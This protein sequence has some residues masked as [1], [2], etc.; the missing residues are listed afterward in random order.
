MATYP[1]ER[2]WYAAY[3]SHTGRPDWALVPAKPAQR[4]NTT[5]TTNNNNRLSWTSLPTR[6][7][8]A[9]RL[10]ERRSA[11]SVCE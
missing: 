2:A 4:L 10:S 8:T 6:F 9:Q 11:E 1:Y 3:Q 7:I 5:T